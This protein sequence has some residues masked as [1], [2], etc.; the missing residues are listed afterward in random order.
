M[1]HALSRRYGYGSIVVTLL[2]T[3]SKAFSMCS[4]G[5]DFNLSFESLTNRDALLLL[6][7]VQKNNPDLWSKISSPQYTADGDQGQKVPDPDTEDD[8]SCALHV[9]TTTIMIMT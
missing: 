2:T 3:T 1:T 4:A 5:G 9:G 8:E 6:C 7:D